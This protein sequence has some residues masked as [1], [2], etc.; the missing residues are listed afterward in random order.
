MTEACQARATAIAGARDDIGR[1]WYRAAAGKRSR[2]PPAARHPIEPAAM[3]ADAGGRIDAVLERLARHGMREAVVVEI[4]SPIKDIHAVRVL[5]PRPRDRS[6][7]GGTARRPATARGFPREAAVKV[8]FAG[9][10][11][12]GDIAALAAR[13]EDITFAGPVA[14]GDVLHWTRRGASAIGIVDGLFHGVPPVWH[15]EI[16]FALSEGVAV[17]GGASMGALR[18][19]ECAAFGMVGLGDVYRLYA[20]GIETRRRRRRAGPRAGGTWLDS[21]LRGRP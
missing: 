12:A 15:K 17:A 6:R 16:L 8:L 3:P 19:A 20:D 10:S 18:A 7:C 14:R 9:P 5:V 1:D 13:H 4:P 21:P 11:L 2:E